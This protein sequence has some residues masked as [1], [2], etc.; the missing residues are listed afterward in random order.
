MCIN[1]IQKGEAVVAGNAEEMVDT[2][3]S[4]S[5]EKVTGHGLRFSA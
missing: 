5:V 2:Y 1:S 4:R 3:L